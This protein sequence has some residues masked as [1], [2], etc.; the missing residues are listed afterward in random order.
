M[1][2]LWRRTEAVILGWGGCCGVLVEL[3]VVVGIVRGEA[4]RRLCL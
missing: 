3:G 2:R 1:V 4:G